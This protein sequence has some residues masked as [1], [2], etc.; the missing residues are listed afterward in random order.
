MMKPCWSLHSSMRFAQ[1]LLLLMLAM[2]VSAMAQ[3]EGLIAGFV[4]R[5]ADGDTLTLLDERHQPYKIRLAGIDAPEKA[6]AFGRDSQQKLYTLCYHK[7][8]VVA[9]VNTDRYGRTVGDV[10]CDDVHANE[11]MVRDGNAWVYR[12]YDRGFESFY[13][14]EAAAREAKLGLWADDDPTPPWVWRHSR[15]LKD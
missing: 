11:V 7:Q 15:R 14:L 13:A 5:V 1:L 10:T 3:A 2:L 8:A 6:Q 4:V 12:Y 9:V